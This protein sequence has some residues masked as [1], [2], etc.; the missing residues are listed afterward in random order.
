MTDIDRNPNIII[1]YADD[2]GYGDIGCYGAKDISTP[3]IDRLAE[4]GLMFTDAYATAATCTPSR[5]SILTGTYPWRVDAHILA[6]DAPLIIEPDSPTL[7]SM[8][9]EA[10][11]VTGVVGKWHLGLGCGDIDWNKEIYHKEIVHLLSRRIWKFA[12]KTG[13]L[14][15]NPYIMVGL[16]PFGPAEAFRD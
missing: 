2:L 16:A 14:C 6:G 12:N 4:Q 8:L 9:Q 15:I 11:Y 1:L 5:Y 10:G 3:N 13:D 7:P